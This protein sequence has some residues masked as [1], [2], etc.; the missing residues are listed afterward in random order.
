MQKCSTARPPAVRVRFLMQ[1]VQ[2]NVEASAK[3]E[4]AYVLLQYVL[5]NGEASAE[6]EAAYAPAAIYTAERRKL[7]TA[8]DS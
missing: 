4:A 5:Q 6:L 3:L 1:F 7:E 2:Q 8:C